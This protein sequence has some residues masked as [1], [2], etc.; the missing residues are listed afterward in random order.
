MLQVKIPLSD[1]KQIAVTVHEPEKSSGVLAILCPGYL[2]SKDYTHLVELSKILGKR[3][4]AVARFDPLGTWESEGAMDDY[5][6][7]HYIEA[8][9]A[10]KNF[11]LKNGNYKTIVLGGHSRGG[12]MSII[13]AATHPDISYVIAIMPS[14]G[15]DKT[16][17]DDEDARTKRSTRDLPNDKSQKKRYDVPSAIVLDGLRYNALEHIAHVKAP[18]LF[19]AGEKDTV[20]PVEE[21]RDIYNKAVSS[22]ELRIIPN[23][24]HDYRHSLEEVLLVNQE[25]GHWLD[26]QRITGSYKLA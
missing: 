13:Y 26:A 20:V 25:I 3:G 14:V 12:R 21:V 10:V 19:I 15:R 9:T 11:M 23:I 2:D 18:I 1:G 17:T 7:A 8:I 4:Y 22:K 16:K 6:M 24:G 5:T